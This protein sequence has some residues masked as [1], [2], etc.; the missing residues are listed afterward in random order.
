MRTSV[1]SVEGEYIGRNVGE[2]MINSSLAN[3]RL[4]AQ[5]PFFQNYIIEPLG[6]ETLYAD[7]RKKPNSLQANQLKG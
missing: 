1:S 2:L 4:D 6:N 3:P 5:V 7:G